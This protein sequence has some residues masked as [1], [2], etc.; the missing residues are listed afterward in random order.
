MLREALG[1]RLVD[2]LHRTGD[3]CLAPNGLS[4][5]ITVTLR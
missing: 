4:K 5:T 2:A 1:N 3:A